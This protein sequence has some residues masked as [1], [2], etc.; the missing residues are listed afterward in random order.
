MA[1]SSTTEP[2]TWEPTW[3]RV[4]I[5]GPYG[6]GKSTLA[7]KLGEA[8]GLPV[9]HL[10]SLLFSRDRSKVAQREWLD[11]HRRLIERDEWVADGNVLDS[12]GIDERLHRSHVAVVLVP[13]RWRATW[14]FMRREARLGI[15]SGRLDALTLNEIRAAWRWSRNR[16]PLLY[17]VLQRHPDLPVLT[18]RSEADVGAL[19]RA[20]GRDGR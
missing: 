6:A 8:T 10:D 9:T 18:I 13:P 7:L 20:A 16:L 12:G 15:R 11:R 17:A 4:A 3:R 19:L 5:V 14:R 2:P 1:R